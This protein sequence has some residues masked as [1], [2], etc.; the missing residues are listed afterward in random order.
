MENI[1]ENLS[2]QVITS[3]NPLQKLAPHFHQT[4][5]ECFKKSHQAETNLGHFQTTMIEFYYGNILEFVT[6]FKSF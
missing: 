1:L 4:T 5:L 3:S 6:I 2:K